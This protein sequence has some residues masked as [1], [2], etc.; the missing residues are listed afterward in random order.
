MEANASVAPD[1]INFAIGAVGSSQTIAPGNAL[2]DITATVA[3]DGWTQGG[4]GYTGPPLIELRGDA[5]VRRNIDGLRLQNVGGCLIRGL[6]INRFTQHGIAI[7][8]G[9]LN[10]I[11]A[12]FI[13]TNAAGDIGLGNDGN[14]IDI[15]GG[16]NIVGTNSDGSNDANEGNLISGNSGNNSDGV[17]ISGNDCIGNIV[18]GNRIGTNALGTAAIPNQ[19]NG[20]RIENNATDNRVGTDGD[21]NSDALEA[22]LISGHTLSGID[23]NGVI[24]TG[25]GTDRNVV[26]GNRIGTDA[27]GSGAIANSIGVSAQNGAA[28]T[29][30]GTNGDE[31]GDL[32][33]RNQISGNVVFGVDL[34]RVVESRVSGNLIG[35]NLAGATALPNGVGVNVEGNSSTNDIGVDALDPRVEQRNVISGN[36]GV[37]V[38]IHGSPETT[39]VSGNFIGTTVSGTTALANG[40]HGVLLSN[41]TDDNVVGGT[42][43]ALANTIAFNGGDGVAVTEATTGPNLILGNSIHHNTG[44]GIDLGNDGVTENDALDLDLGPNGQQN[45]PVVIQGATTITFTIIS[46][47]STTYRA[48]FFASTAADPTGHGEGETFLGSTD[49]TTDPAGIVHGSFSTTLTAVPLVTAI[50]ATATGPDGTSEFGLSRLAPTAANVSVGGRVLTS[51]G[52]GISG[53]LVTMSSL[54]GDS[55]YARTNP[56]GFYNFEDVPAAATYAVQA[57]HKRYVFAPVIVTVTDQISDL[58]FIAEPPKL[59]AGR[60]LPNPVARLP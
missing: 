32:S 49:V 57:S 3:I 22:N 51:D 48:E 4:P 56:F 10:I 21:G 42:L 29:V 14:G 43:A 39:R 55:R 11:Q 44:L 46:R 53:A 1:T 41:G 58:D 52:H 9:G 17:L 7:A 25:Q 6:V 34:A 16:N 12:N 23:S 20:I 60:R 27:V 15:D 30:I 54:Q 8:R 45:F 26:A 31:V 59:G 37:G 36:I 47:P 5:N 35:T 18:A 50:S 40:S 33:E 24:I 19:D 2:P 28:A 13:G 38:H